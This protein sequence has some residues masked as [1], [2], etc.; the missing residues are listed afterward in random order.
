MKIRKDTVA[1]IGI[2]LCVAAFVA[3][4]AIHAIPNLL[5]FAPAA[6]FIPLVITL[7]KADRKVEDDEEEETPKKKINW[8]LL[9]AWTLVG[10]TAV[11]AILTAIFFGWLFLL[12]LAIM[13]GLFIWVAYLLSWRAFWTYL[14][15]V[16]IVIAI[17]LLGVYGI[18]G[19]N[20]MNNNGHIDNL[21][22]DNLYAEDATIGNADIDNA[23]IEDATI[24]NADIEDATIGNADVE[25][26]DIENAVIDNAVIEE[27]TIDNAV[28]ENA[29]VENVTISTEPETTVPSE[30][31]PPAT[32]PEPT[33]PVHTHNYTSVVTG[34]TCMEQGYTT[35]TCECGHSYTDSRKGA[36]GHSYKSTVVEPTTEAGGYTE[37]Q[38]ERCG[39]T[40]KADFTD[41]LVN[42]KLTQKTTL[43]YGSPAEVTF[44]GISY[45]ALRIHNADLAQLNR[46]SE[47][48]FEVELLVDVTGEVVISN[49]EGE[50][51]LTLVIVIE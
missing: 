25:N 47:N 3:I 36:L 10:L 19:S 29:T 35:H 50:H 37:Y 44:E 22:V 1:W 42:P 41:K 12:P 2:I 7:Y 18:V 6:L 4:I 49:A 14:F 43:K 13:F 5:A 39:H 51:L 24:G 27:A 15:M 34:P 16:L 48:T 31:T 11:C 40:Y 30:T 45:D 9:I 32:E 38:C 21:Y 23:D 33:E 28:I 8:P 46:L 20:G 26:A 17:I